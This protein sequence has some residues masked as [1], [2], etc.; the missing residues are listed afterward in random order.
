MSRSS[1]PPKQPTIEHRIEVQ[2]APDHLSRLASARK[3]VL[4]IAEL[5]W[6]ALDADADNVRV[7][8]DRND[9]GGIEAIRVSDDGAGMTRAVI[10]EYFG[11]LG[12][13]WKRSTSFTQRRRVLHGKDG[14]G[15]FKAFALGT[16]VEWLTRAR[17]EDGTEEELSVVGAMS[18]LTEFIVRPTR[19]RKLPRPGTTV[20]ITNTHVKLP[21]ISSETSH[22]AVEALTE[23]FALYLMQYPGISLSYNSEPID[24]RAAAERRE[25]YSIDVVVPD[26]AEKFSANLTVIEWKHYAERSL[27]LCDGDGFTL[28]ELPVA[29]RLPGFNFTAYVRS[30][31]V[32]ELSQSNEL[33]A[34]ELHPVVGAIA[35]A[36]RDKIGDHFR[37]RRAEETLSRVEQWKSEKIYPYKGTPASPVEQVERQVFDVC[38]ANVETLVPDFETTDA[39]AKTL[40]FR[41]LRQAIEKG[42]EDVQRI[43]SEV[44]ELPTQK[45]RQLAKLLDRTTLAAIINTSSLI[46]DRV[47]FLNG[48]E[49]LIFDAETKGLL[50]ERSQLHRLLAAN[51]WIF[52]E[53]FHLSVDDEGLTK[54]LKKHLELLGDDRKNVA[55]VD[56]V[57]GHPLIVDL[58]LSRRVPL[59]RDEERQHL[60][61]ELKRP[62][63]KITMEVIN[64][65]MNYAVTVAED[66]RFRGTRTHWTFWALSSDIDTVARVHANQAGRP[67]GLAYDHREFPLTIWVK[68]WGQVIEECR[69][70]LAFFQKTLEYKATHESGKSYLAELYAEL[71]PDSADTAA[72]VAASVKAGV[73]AESPIV[74][75]PPTEGASKDETIDPTPSA[76]GSPPEAP[77]SAS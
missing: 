1:P 21:G 57:T 44:L 55:A 3:S 22:A 71:L 41:L 46:A 68:T 14:E 62:S 73:I 33:K 12:G 27:C 65:V 59:P 11:R 47:E 38:A 25:E 6:N 28:L 37:K 49:A 77:N 76:D 75:E 8:I 72:S 70:R 61:V 40:M 35:R 7:N 74:E 23:H 51:T 15:R 20:T 56:T 29:K 42:P 54:A 36:A 43:L 34:E 63:V 32:R 19:E 17:L 2:L 30:P 58:M 52:G 9:L 5:I 67:S 69:G 13:S 16:R 53:E 39:R 4:A 64:Q 10:D 45:Q 48:L 66:E 26:G 60:V 24:P 50:K 31:R 18:A